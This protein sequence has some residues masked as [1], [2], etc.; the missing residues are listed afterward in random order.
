MTTEPDLA[1]AVLAGASP[2]CQQFRRDLLQFGS[3]L[4][5]DG[6]ELLAMAL[7]LAAG[8]AKNCARNAFVAVQRKTNCKP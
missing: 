1:R 8:S 7:R 4:S 2:H 6:N 3:L 5:V